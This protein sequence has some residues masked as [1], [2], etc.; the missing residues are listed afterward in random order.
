[1]YLHGV[2]GVLR[3]EGATSELAPLE[4]IARESLLII[5]ESS[6]RVAAED[7]AQ[8]QYWFPHLVPHIVGLLAASA[9]NVAPAQAADYV[10]TRLEQP[11]GVDWTDAWMCHAAASLPSDRV[12]IEPLL[13]FLTR[14]HGQPLSRAEAM[15]A[16]SKAGALDE[17][18]WR[19]VL[20][21]SSPA[22]ATEMLLAALAEPEHLPWLGHYVESAHPAI[23]QVAIALRAEE[24]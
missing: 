14:E 10:R 23:A 13:L 18:E 2:A 7:L 20:K 8:V 5:R 16:L 21:R 12:P 15:R 22:L 17:K 1:M 11:S 9:G 19:R 24:S 3:D 4:N 6:V